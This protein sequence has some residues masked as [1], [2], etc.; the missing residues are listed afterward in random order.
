MGM[1]METVKK[2]PAEVAKKQSTETMKKQ[3]M[4]STESFVLYKQIGSTRYRLG[5][6]FN[7]NAKETLDEKICRLLKNDL[8]SAREDA[9][10]KPLQA[11]CLSERGIL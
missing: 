7:P 4:A 10:I 11:G 8:Q 1:P 9:T 5:I 2:Q 3:S 6:Y